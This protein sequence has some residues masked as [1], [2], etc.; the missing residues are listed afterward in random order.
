MNECVL[1]SESEDLVNI[2]TKELQMHIQSIKQNYS[3]QRSLWC[4]F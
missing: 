1:H 2:I 4:R 3:V